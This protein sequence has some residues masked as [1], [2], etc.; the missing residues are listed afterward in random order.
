MYCPEYIRLRQLYEVAIRQWGHVVLSPDSDSLGAPIA[1]AAEI[2]QKAYRERDEAK[3]RLSDHM[4]TC[5]V[6]NP[7][8]RRVN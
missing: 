3:R 1:L 2:K 4:V 8:R 6:C 5:S 7:K